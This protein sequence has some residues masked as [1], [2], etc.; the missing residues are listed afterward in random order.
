MSFYAL[1]PRGRLRDSLPVVMGIRVRNRNSDPIPFPM[2]IFCHLLDSRSAAG[3]FRSDF[4]PWWEVGWVIGIACIMV[5]LTR[6]KAWSKLRWVSLSHVQ[7]NQLGTIT[8]NNER[9]QLTHW[10]NVRSKFLIFGD[11]T[12]YKMPWRCLELQ[13]QNN[14]IVRVRFLVRHFASVLGRGHSGGFY[15]QLQNYTFF[16]CDSNMLTKLENLFQLS[17][18]MFSRDILCAISRRKILVSPF[19]PFW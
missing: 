6:W 5:A 15:N 12:K 11:K 8:W 9:V 3:I 13:A 16:D 14:I 19:G 7:R 18:G 17:R 4:V 2:A 1:S 10:R